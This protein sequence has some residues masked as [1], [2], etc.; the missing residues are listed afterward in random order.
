[1]KLQNQKSPFRAILQYFAVVL[2]S[3]SILSVIVGCSSSSPTEVTSTLIRIEFPFEPSFPGYIIDIKSDVFT[4]NLICDLENGVVLNLDDSSD[5]AENWGTCDATSMTLDVG[6]PDQMTVTAI[7]GGFP[8]INE[9][10]KS[11]E[12]ISGNQGFCNIS[13]G[14]NL[15]KTGADDHAYPMSF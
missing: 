3:V 4:A 2:V 15:E 1:M 12:K 6:I 13:G 14:R 8:F 7:L 9:V 11:P 5:S 10:T